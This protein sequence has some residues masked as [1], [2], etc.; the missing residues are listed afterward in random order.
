[1]P[2]GQTRTR[3]KGIERLFDFV[4]STANIQDLA[5]LH[6]TTPDEAQTLAER[7]GPIFARE[8]IV[9][10]RLGTTL[11]VHGGPGLLFVVLRQ[12]KPA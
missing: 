9:I 7:I 1:M 8:K 2:A 3:S 12:K 5:I 10:A 4:K 6:N 11:G